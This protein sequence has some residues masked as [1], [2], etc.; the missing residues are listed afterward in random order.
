MPHLIIEYARELEDEIDISTLMVAVQNAAIESAVMHAADIKV[1]AIPHDHY[2]LAG[3]RD[4]FVH[5][6]VYL[7]EGRAN[8][9]KYKLSNLIRQAKAELLPQ[10]KSLS[11]DIRDMNPDA[12]LKRLLVD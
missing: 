1:R 5:T 8:E 2:L 12:Y 3:R 9:E 6:T 4:R 11:I 10:I 7:L